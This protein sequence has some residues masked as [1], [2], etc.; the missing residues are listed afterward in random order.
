MYP[1][2]IGL[3][4]EK[5]ELLD[6]VQ[7]CLHELPVRIQFEQPGITDW[8]ELAD[9]LVRSRPDVVILD[10]SSLGRPLAGDGQQDQRGGHLAD[11]DRVERQSPIRSR[12][13]RPFVPVFTSTCFRRC[14]AIFGGHW[15]AVRKNGTSSA[16]A[17]AKG[18]LLVSFPPRA[19]AAPPLSPATRQSRSRS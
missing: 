11:A 13:W 3:I 18:G 5:K 7:A 17:R 6:E 1:L 8:V 14:T 9:K 15:S 12:S 4:I 16:R 10:V 2:T 19:A